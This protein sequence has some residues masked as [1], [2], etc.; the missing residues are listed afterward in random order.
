MIC[1]S[2]RQRS[3]LRLMQTEASNGSRSAIVLKASSASLPGIS[4]KT[5]NGSVWPIW[6]A[7]KTPRA[8]GQ[9][10]LKSM[11]TAPVYR[12]STTRRWTRQQEM[13]FCKGDTAAMMEAGLSSI[14]MG[15]DPPTPCWGTMLLKG[16]HAMRGDPC[17]VLAPAAAIALTMRALA[18]PVTDCVRPSVRA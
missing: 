8:S 7:S 10:A 2:P 18:F 14:G 11:L 12:T 15:V 5:A 13:Q 1:V 3:S 6:F 4:I 16:A 17:F 9:M